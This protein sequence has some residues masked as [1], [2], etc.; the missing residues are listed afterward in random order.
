MPMSK[1]YN[2]EEPHHHAASEDV[3]EVVSK[4]EKHED[5]LLDDNTN[6]IALGIS[7]AGLLTVAGA[8]ALRRLHRGRKE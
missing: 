1:D 8:I 5:E 7:A 4:E 2:P 3:F 6:R